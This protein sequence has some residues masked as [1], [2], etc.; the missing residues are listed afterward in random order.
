VGLLATES[1]TLEDKRELIARL[2]D[3]DL[4]RRAPRQREFL[5]Y[6]AGCTL[7]NCLDGVREQV[8]AEK[9]FGRAADQYDIG[10]TIV[11][12]EA[13]NLRKRLEKYFETEGLGESCIV[14]MPMGG[15]ALAFQPRA[16][17]PA[18]APASTAPI[19]VGEPVQPVQQPRKGIVLTIIVAVLLAAALAIVRGISPPHRATAAASTLPFSALFSS[20]RNTLIITSDTAFLQIA[21][22]SHRRFRLDDYLARSYPDVPGVSPPDLIRNLNRFQYTDADETSIAAAILRENAGSIQRAHLRSGHQVSLADFKDSNVILLGSLISNPW[23]ELYSNRLNFEFDFKTGER[24]ILRNK[25]P[26]AGEAGT[27][28]ARDD[29][30]QNR[31]YAHIAFIPDQASSALLIAGTTAEATQAAGELLLDRNKF[32]ATLKTMGL[33]PAGPPRFFEMLLRAKTFIGGAA[34][35]ELVAYRTKAS[36]R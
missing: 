36:S 26:L 24:I 7:D 23:A 9:V 2:A 21:E 11:R 13:R 29:A 10:D 32:A 6:V 1:Q 20:S 3:S 16:E 31:T 34:E 28:P 8:I 5:L 19:A 4:F 25:S 12:A 18:P 35:S 14:A 22:L 30:T 33:N 17:E 15:Y 27:Y